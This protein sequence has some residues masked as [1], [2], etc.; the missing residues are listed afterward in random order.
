VGWS[1]IKVVGYSILSLASA[2]VVKSADL[3]SHTAS[4][5]GMARDISYI[6]KILSSSSDNVVRPTMMKKFDGR[7][8]RCILCMFWLCSGPT[9]LLIPPD[10]F[11]LLPSTS[12]LK[13]LTTHRQRL[14][15]GQINGERPHPRPY[16]APTR[17]DLVHSRALSCITL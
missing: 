3:T 7:H 6:S 4:S 16:T 14:E 1:S 11:P 17:R 13:A 15:E 8:T 12:G 9:H 2:Y 10:S 5:L